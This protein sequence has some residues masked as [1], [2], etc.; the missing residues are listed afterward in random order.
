V[1][2]G[3]FAGLDPARGDPETPDAIHPMLHQNVPNPFNPSTTIEYSL[4]VDAHVRLTVFD[5]R[6]RK[7][8]VLAD[9]HR[10]AGTHRVTWNAVGLPSGIYF[11]R[12]TAGAFTATR[13]M[14]LLR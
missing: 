7:A 14:C 8:A 9:G 10:P 1:H 11:Y 2:F 13:K 12:I 4:P 5:A 3:A 6:G